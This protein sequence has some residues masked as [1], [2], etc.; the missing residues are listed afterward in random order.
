MQIKQ[1]L[2]TKDLTLNGIV[3]K[4]DATLTGG[5]FTHIIGYWHKKQGTYVYNYDKQGL[6]FYNKI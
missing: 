6:R 3:Y 2:T 5:F 1:T 4:Y